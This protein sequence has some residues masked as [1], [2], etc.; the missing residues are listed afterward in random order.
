MIPL[1]MRLSIRNHLVVQMPHI[2]YLGHSQIARTEELVSLVCHQSPFDL[3][4]NFCSCLL[5][6]LLIL[7]NR[8]TRLSRLTSSVL[9]ALFL[10][11]FQL[12]RSQKLLTV[13]KYNR[14]KI[15]PEVKK[16]E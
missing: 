2:L 16:E 13:P 7:K 5:K 15:Q 11:L 8:L 4:F 9:Q 10:M 1:W 12:V 14:S 6:N 3:W